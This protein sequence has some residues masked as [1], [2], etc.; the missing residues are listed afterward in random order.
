MPSHNHGLMRVFWPSDAPRDSIP[1]VLVGWRNSDLDVLIV[2]V[3]QGV[4][5]RNVD[6]ALRMRTLFR[7]SPYSIDKLVAHCGNQQLQVLGT[8]NIEPASTI[9]DPKLLCLHIVP[10]SA[11]PRVER[12]EYAPVTFQ[13]ITFDR[14]DPRRMQYLSLTPISLALVDKSGPHGGDS[15]FDRIDKDEADARKK[16]AS[17]VE[18]LK[19]HS[20]I[21]HARSEKEMAL[22]N[23][24][25]QINCSAE[26]DALLQSNIGMV[27][28]R[29][30]RAMSVGE[31]V[32]ESATNF[33]DYVQ[34]ESKRSFRHHVW[35]FL[36]Q[37]VVLYLMVLRIA[38]EVLLSL[39]D[40]RPFGQAALKDIS[41]TAQQ[42]D[43][44]LQQFCY[45]PDQ[46][47]TL[48]RRRNDW[49]SITNSHPDYIRF[50]NSLWLVANDVIIGIALGSYIVENVDYVAYLLDTTLA[51]YSVAGLQQ[52]LTWLMDYPAGLKLNNELA[53]FLGDLFLWVIEYWNGCM[54]ELRPALPS[55]IRI[56]GITS[57]AGASLPISMFSDLL[58]VLT[59]HIYCFYVASARIYNWQLTIIISLFHLF[60]GKK[61][62]ILRSRIDSCDYDLD[63]LL[64]GTI[65]FTL[66][67]FLLPTVAVFYAT[68]AGA[69]MAIIALKAALDTWLA[70][71]NHF[72]LFA[73][74]LRVKDSRRLP[75]GIQFELQDPPR[76]ISSASESSAEVGKV[77]PT[78]YIKLK[79]IPLPLS[80]TFSQ[81]AQLGQRL[82]K[83]YLL[84]RVFLCLVSGQFVPPI[85]RK[86][87]Y[88]LQYSML[89]VKRITI[90]ELWQLLTEQRPVEH[91]QVNGQPITNGHI[92]GGKKMNGRLKAAN[93]YWWSK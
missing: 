52:M 54:T 42:V 78:S 6:H 59:M 61:R 68:F 73:L 75:G 81:Y 84:P 5:P 12:Y 23:I 74:M 43:I 55:L 4:E 70:C 80:Q 35:P 11:T 66:L 72:P 83:H 85:H 91:G 58:S 30:K 44:R 79:S 60:R 57:F 26:L 88:S 13:I 14:P 33:W 49:E 45:W 77:A 7:G 37:V 39:L 18:K 3:L 63:Q 87:L 40:W 1:G 51:E 10:R 50:F 32:V 69:R 86:N 47:V 36:R 29:T 93:G 2:A 22:N 34:L 15:S 65:L 16:K 71:L 76:I 89:P 62:N 21:R 56:I 19:Q 41:A 82:R 92:G 38:A 24:V 17:L 90:G 31:R 67:F 8:L 53:T 64:L 25:V 27:G 9:F 28:V 20:V 48:N 46:Y